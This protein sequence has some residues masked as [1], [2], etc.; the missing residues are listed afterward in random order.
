MTYDELAVRFI[1]TGNR[2]GLAAL[3]Q[4][5]A[6]AVGDECPDCGSNET[7]SNG[8]REYRCICCDWRWGHECGAR[9]GF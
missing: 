2:R 4:D 6:Y 7:E 9:Y 8:A 3:A 5:A 1:L